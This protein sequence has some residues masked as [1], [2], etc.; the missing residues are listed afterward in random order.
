[1]R[2]KFRRSIA[3]LAGIVLVGGAIVL[4]NHLT[5]EDTP[6]P[7][8]KPSAQQ[9][10]D[11]IRRKDNEKTE[12]QE[13]DPPVTEFQE[14]EPPV[15]PTEP[16]VI[17]TEPPVEPT[18]PPVIPTEPP[19][20]P[21]DPPVEP[22][23]PPVE[24]TEP[25]V[26]PTEP[27]VEPTEPPVVPT[28]PPVEPTEPPVEPTEP[29]VEPTE[30]P[31]VPT[32][33]PVEPTEPP[34]EPTEPPVVPTEPPVEPTEPPVEPTEPPVEP[35]EPPVEPTEPPVVP[36]EP[37]VEPTE[38]PVEPTEPPVEPTDPPPI[39]R[40]E[41]KAVDFGVYSAQTGQLVQL[42]DY[43]GK[44]IVLN[45]WASW[46]GPC[47]YEMPDFN[48]M[49]LQ[50]GDEVQFLMVNLTGYETLTSAMNFIRD[51]G[52]VFPVFYDFTLEGAQAYGVTSIP[53]TIFIDAEG[54]VISQVTGALSAYELQHFIRLLLAA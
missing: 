26:V 23:E 54:Y 44:P 46:C 13:T 43:I 2:N 17:P 37:P 24:P 38:P 52:Y 36:T 42:S 48:Q 4:T 16:P 34:V 47:R 14:T 12:P 33:P 9:I 27:P 10:A 41:P 50:Y 32:E 31:V 25:P 49:Y 28:E 15:V 5:K 29:P 18:E 20:V 51:A 35:T 11:S 30:P 53:T 7:T 39:E 1:M 21:T 6:M 45:F 8:E 40:Q 3:I 19:V 22:T